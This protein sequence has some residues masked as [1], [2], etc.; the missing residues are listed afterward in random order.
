MEWF[1]VSIDGE[2]SST[3]CAN[4]LRKPSAPPGHVEVVWYEGATHDFEDPGRAR[5][6]FAANRAAKNDVMHREAA[7]FDA[8]P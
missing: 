5:Q 6:A 1:A 4:V 2:V 8:L 3:I 7:L